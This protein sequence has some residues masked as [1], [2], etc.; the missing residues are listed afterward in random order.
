MPF[1]DKS[2]PMVIAKDEAGYI[3][4]LHIHLKTDEWNV[5]EKNDDNFAT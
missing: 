3:K 5:S 4:K 2:V 1:V